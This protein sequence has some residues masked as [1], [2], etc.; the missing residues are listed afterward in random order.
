MKNV[1]V[2]KDEITIKAKADNG[3]V[4]DLG[5]AE[6]NIPNE[7][8]VYNAFMNNIKLAMDYSVKNLTFIVTD[9]GR[10]IIS[11]KYA[12]NSMLVPQKIAPAVKQPAETKTKA[13]NKQEETKQ[14]SK[15][16][17]AKTAKKK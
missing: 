14:I 15:K 1:W 12:V 9:N 16:Q 5:A 11:K 2:K 13:E 8:F 7:D 17:S 3:K 6:I 10:E 4:I